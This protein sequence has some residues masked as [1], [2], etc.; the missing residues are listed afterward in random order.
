MNAITKIEHWAE[1]HHPNWIDIIRIA[2]GLTILYKGILFISNTAALLQLMERADLQ[3]VHLGIAHY[4]A[5]AHLVGGILIALGLV[6][7]IA[8]LFQLPILLVAV[9]LVNVK[10]GFFTVSNNLEFELSL[11]VLILL[12]VFLIYGSGKWSIDHWMK[13]HP[14][15]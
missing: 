14:N 15:E 3:F 1:S 11:I 12:I 6:T 5:F 2:L 10:Q 7:R 13:M 4:V 8:I 9:F